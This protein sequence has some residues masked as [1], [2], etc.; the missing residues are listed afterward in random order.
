MM[1]T[2]QAYLTMFFESARKFWQ[3]FDLKKWADGV[4]GSSAE[5]VMATVYFLLSF[6]VGFLCRKYFKY[7]FIC[8][9]FTFFTIKGLEYVK[10]IYVDWRAIRYVTGMVTGGNLFETIFSW[11]R[12]HLLLFVATVI[13]FLVGY[14]LG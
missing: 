8:V 5:A 10:I 9:L 7:V 6:A 4:G 12:M 14:K 3:E 1:E 2:V 13:G 11:I